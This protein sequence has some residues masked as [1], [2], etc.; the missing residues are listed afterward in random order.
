MMSSSSSSAMSTPSR[1][2][3]RRKP[4]PQR[5]TL[6]RN[7]SLFGSIKN[8]VA[9]PFSRLFASSEEFEDEKDFS[10]KRRRIIPQTKVQ[11][12]DTVD[13]GPAPKRMR[14]NSP[15][16]SPPP[17]NRGG[18][19]D[20]PASA[21]RQVSP[22]LYNPPSRSASITIPSTTMSDINTRSTVS[23]LRRQLST[24][25]IIDP[26]SSTTTYNRV[27]SRD[28]S[29]SSTSLVGSAELN[30]S[31]LQ[32][33]ERPR[34]YSMPPLSGKPSF[35]MRSSMTPQPQRDTSEPPPITSLS[36]YPV[37]VRGPSQVN[38]QRPK[39]GTSTLGSL[40]DSQRKRQTSQTTSTVPQRNSL[41]FGRQVQETQPSAVLQE[42]DFYRT[43]LVPTRL[44]SKV[45]TAGNTNADITAM[46][47]RKQSLILMGDDNRVR[48]GGRRGSSKEKKEMAH[49]ESKPYAGTT[50]LKKRLAKHRQDEE[51]SLHKSR[52][53]DPC[54]DDMMLSDKP[55]GSEVEPV[56][57]QVPPPPPPPAG[58][59]WFSLAKSS[60][61]SS[62][63]PEASSLRVGR[64]SRSHLS[65]PSRPSKTKFSAAFEEDEEVSEEFRAEMA[66]LEE[67]AKKVPVFQVPAGFSFAKDT[68]AADADAANAKEPP[69]PSLPFS[70][71][72][73]DSAF[74]MSQPRTK[75]P[76]PT[77]TPSAV[78]VPATEPGRQTSP[79]HVPEIASKT[80]TTR[81]T[82]ESTS[83]GKIPNFFASSKFLSNENTPTP[84]SQTPTAPIQLSSNSPSPFAVPS[85]STPPL[86]SAGS[87][88]L[89]SA[90]VPARENNTPLWRDEKK[91][92]ASSSQ[93]GGVL[94]GIPALF[95]F[96][97][98]NA[99]SP[100]GGPA[101]GAVE[102]SDAKSGDTNLSFS[103]TKSATEGSCSATSLP[104]SLGPSAT[105]I[106][107]TGQPKISSLP[108][109]SSTASTSIFSN[110]VESSGLSAT[111]PS[112]LFGGTVEKSAFQAE[113]PKSATNDGPIALPSLFGQ[114]QKTESSGSGFSVAEKPK[115][116][117]LFGQ[118]SA[119]QNSALTSADS[120][121]SPFSFT[122]PTQSFSFGPETKT[123]SSASTS[124]STF[125][126][127]SSSAIGISPNS[128]KT[129]PFA[130]GESSTGKSDAPKSFLFGN[131]SNAS[132][133][134]TDAK[135][136]SFGNATSSTET[137]DSS[138]SL[139][140]GNG[141][142]ASSASAEPSK[143][144]PFGTG[145]PVTSSPF[146]E[147]KPSFSFGFSSRP[148]TP[149]P[150]PDNEVRMEESPTRDTQKP[151]E[152]RPS[153]SGFPFGTSTSSPF[154]QSAQSSSGTASSSFSFGVPSTNDNNFGGMKTDSKPASSSFGFGQ[155]D[156]TSTTPNSS[157]F[158]FGFN[159]QDNEPA[160]PST[161]GSFSF[162]P[163]PSTSTT[164]FT[165]GSSS[166]TTSNPFGPP[167][168]GSAPSSPSTF[169]QPTPAFTGSSNPFAFGGSQPASP[170]TPSSSLPQSSAFG[171]SPSGF[172]STQPAAGALFTM[173]AAPANS[174]G[175]HIKRLP[176]RGGKR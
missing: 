134:T 154:G 16:L 100:F 30:H 57:T 91:D 164:P 104:F 9:A 74:S 49:N 19:L 32:S 55:A 121:S 26:H 176:K 172:G 126:F 173:G 23:P 152:P 106:S 88:G 133:I 7:S 145:A 113:P 15:S 130:F 46:F 167:Q 98:H 81:T 70:L 63:S 159:K 144:F 149:P 124:G 52:D 116:D 141:T 115:S 13:D 67:A 86:S 25:M 136:L 163:S 18:Y 48:L 160:R 80:S 31:K 51:E 5:K 78:T 140:F 21:F 118:S 37:F 27:P 10:G 132:S 73:S 87:P 107:G 82:A 105:V 94:E 69:L 17:V 50:G 123:T 1:D 120:T 143:S 97:P 139:S 56:P 71:T 39:I 3:R 61:T 108:V 103:F 146:G 60:A 147:S 54:K 47:N 166:N 171:A 93:A 75:S 155:A 102:R 111:S 161:T 64:A 117:S 112:S 35:I 20:P 162:G 24:S 8:F 12:T 59:D 89:V 129:K 4:H 150:N 101:T 11:N 131:D 137:N 43:P 68:T 119:G 170:A 76:E 90:A 156:Y 29:M 2:S 114:S 28:G 42:L 85:S 122:A 125:A 157:P 158:S 83:E 95:S 58:K 40:V 79:S 151:A 128:P 22:V 6:V 36:S 110:T 138:K 45:L 77:R 92:D 175:R 169:S 65:R 72:P 66:A 14:V 168:S 135:P 127:G 53:D 99:T 153:L 109:A 96:T 148:V 142:S 84:G 44:R 33:A 174:Q 34:D 62:S 41:L 165:F 38:E